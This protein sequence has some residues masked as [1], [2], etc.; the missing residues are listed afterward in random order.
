[1]HY[2]IAPYEEAKLVSC[3][4]GA[5]YDVI[6]DLRPDSPTYCQSV[7]VTLHGFNFYTH[8]LIHPSSNKLLYIPEG[9]AHG[10]LTLSDNAEVFYQMSEF[11]MPEYARGI[12]WNDSAFN[13]SWPIDVAV[14]SEKDM[15][16]PN[17]S[18]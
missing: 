4:R 5:I 18:L 13:I 16:Y 15:Q 8:P 7:A 10:F 1:M 6:I 3:I 11:Y 12:R 17:F 14:I 9:F 2:Q